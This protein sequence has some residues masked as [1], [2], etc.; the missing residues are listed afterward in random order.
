MPTDSPSLAE[1]VADAKRM[2]ASMLPRPRVDSPRTIDLTQLE[3]QIPETT[4][5]LVDEW[6]PYGS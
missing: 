1:L 6:E 3:I 2:P 4:A 5:S